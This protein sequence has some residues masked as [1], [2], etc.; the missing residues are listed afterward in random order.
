MNLTA[1]PIRFNSTWRTRTSSSSSFGGSGS[2]GTNSN[3]SPLSAALWA[4]I[5]CTSDSSCVS[6]TGPGRSSIFIASILERSSTSLIS[7]SSALPEVLIA[8]ENATRCAS[9]IRGERSRSLRP[10]TAFSGVRIS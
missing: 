1:L 9:E 8:S 10:I 2:G 4:K 3:S 7:C 5:W 6:D